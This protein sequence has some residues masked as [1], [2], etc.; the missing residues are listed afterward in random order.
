M[1]DKENLPVRVAVPLSAI[2]KLDVAQRYCR[3][4]YLSDAEI[5]NE[6]RTLAIDDFLNVREVKTALEV[7]A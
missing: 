4:V 7:H 3:K 6:V 2:Q 5:R 1:V